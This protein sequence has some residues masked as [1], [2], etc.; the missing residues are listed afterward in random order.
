MW[1]EWKT[2]LGPWDARSQGIGGWTLDVHHAYDPVGR[3]LY[4]GY[5]GRR[6]ADESQGIIDTAAGGGLDNCYEGCPASELKMDRPYGVALAPD[7][8][9]YLAD[10]F[11]SKIR[12]VRP[13]GT[14]E[15]VAPEE[16]FNGPEDVA[17]DSM[18]NLYIADAKN[19][20][21]VRVAS[22]GS[23]EDFAG[24]GVAGFSGDGGQAIDAQFRS[25]ACLVSAPDGSLYVSDYGN[26]RIRR[27]APDGIVQTIAGDGAAGFAGDGGFAVDARLNGPGG[28]DASPDGNIVF[29]DEGN[30]R[31][32]LIGPDGII[33]TVSGGGSQNFVDGLQATDIDMKVGWPV[34]GPDG[35]IYHTAV[36]HRV[37]RVA[38]NGVITTVA[39]YRIGG[40]SGFSG[41]GGPAPAAEV[42]LPLGKALG[43]S[44]D[45]FVADRNNN[46]LRQVKLPFPFFLNDAIAIPSEDGN[47]LHRFDAYGR[48]IDTIHALTGAL[49][50]EFSYDEN[51]LLVS[52][53]DGD[54]NL[55]TIERDGAGKPLAIVAPF[56]QR[57]ELTLDANG[58]LASVTNPEDDT[59]HAAYT[60]KG[61]M[62]S[63]QDPENQTSTFTYHEDGRLQKDENASEGCKELN[64]IEGEK[65]FAVDLATAENLESQYKTEV[66]DDNRKVKTITFPDGTLNQSVE[67][68]DGKTIVTFADGMVAETVEGPDPRFG[69]LSAV[70]ESRAL[71][72]P[73]GLIHQTDSEYEG[74][75]EDAADP[76]TLTS[77]TVETTV[78]GQVFTRVYDAAART[79]TATTPESRQT[80][81]TLDAK[82][83][84]SSYQATDIA[85]VGFAY[86]S[87]GR[88]ET[89]SFGAREV[90]F[91]YDETTGFLQSVTNPLEETSSYTYDA[92]GRITGL[93]LP[94][95]SKWEFERD[96][97]GNLK[98]LI[99]PDGETAHAFAY[100]PTSLL[101]TYASP[102]DAVETFTYDKDDRLV[103]RQ[104]PSGDC[105][106][107]IYDEK[108]HLSKAK[109]PQGDH[110][111]IYD[112]VSGRL[113]QAVS[114]D[115]QQ[116][117]YAYDGSLATRADWTGLATGTV[118]YTYDNDF[119]V[120]R[121]DY[122]GESL[123]VS[124]DNDGLP[125]GIG[126]ITITRNAA[127]GLVEEIEDGDFSIAYTRNAHGEVAT[128]TAVHGATTLY[129]V[130]TTYDDLG[131]IAQKTETIGGNTHVWSFQYDSVGRLMEVKR[132]SAVVESYDYDDTGNR[133]SVTNTLTGASLDSEDFSYDDDNKLLAAGTTTYGYDADG[134]L[135]QVVRNGDITTCHYNTDGT[136]AALDLPEGRQI[137][138]EHD[139]LG[140]RVARSIDGVRTH[141]WLY[142][143]GL[144]PLAEYD[145]TGNLRTLYIHAGG[146]T[147]VKMVRSGATYRIVSDHL[148]SPRLVVDSAGAVIR[149]ID[150]DSFGNVVDDSNRSFDL[151]VGFAGG[152]ADPDSEL[153]RFGARDYQPSTGRWTGKDPIFFHGGL[154]LYG[155]AGGDPVN[156]ADRIGMGKVDEEEIM[157]KDAPCDGV[158]GRAGDPPLQMRQIA[159]GKLD[160][161]KDMT[162]D[163]IGGAYGIF[164]NPPLPMEQ[165]AKGKV[166]IYKPI[167]M[168]C[169]V[170]GHQLKYPQQ[171][172]PR[173]I[174][175]DYSEDWVIAGGN[176]TGIPG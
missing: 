104:L 65:M 140:R 29:A 68:T 70:V 128:A 131:R 114:R 63:F 3:I 22:D 146:A 142:G 120:S 134:R 76:T 106:E 72:T 5:G 50:Y 52:V 31:I 40:G 2:S 172:S 105:L 133:I 17:L 169:T 108:G 80:V 60:E 124:Y 110:D 94:D 139:H 118:A 138:Y 167:N 144:T 39:G 156:N 117:A 85:T 25:P 51:G 83:R 77:L 37:C 154:N 157:I 99:E 137:S 160:E 155:Y 150:Y 47:L 53:E 87:L 125:V 148:G 93:T 35:S 75:F 38:A 141:A 100:T 165:I 74:V 13:D 96:R 28:I 130:G 36:D 82:G 151:A 33:S 129:N 18:G 44:G 43:H 45:L 98:E 113:T 121:I 30:K 42:S 136:L 135:R 12:V 61:L 7:G 89:L 161:G 168:D 149:Q 91:S 79:W 58:W 126:S 59:W 170:E 73:G 132:D 173:Q 55:T 171:F 71:R 81:T 41:D 34:F 123:A 67:Q 21:V 88:V 24:T 112:A 56:G 62:T 46:R 111:F 92:A 163:S 159:K 95:G 66:L 101:Q 176:A 26:H 9:V 4:P 84:L 11:R 16:T 23:V 54:G 145:G 14:A 115:G 119:R 109:T 107:W 127:N 122:A 147:P 97:N 64:R 166:K 158:Y 20:R 15:T 27:I 86:D 57:T 153:I 49:V 10:T 116:I 164:I 1:Q 90:D 19:H 174:S 102:L 32:R 48:H 69:M 152:I 103:E 175:F 162:Q 143:E 6:K 8:S 78:N